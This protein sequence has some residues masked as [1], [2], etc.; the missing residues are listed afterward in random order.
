MNHYYNKKYHP[1]LMQSSLKQSGTKTVNKKN[2]LRILKLVAFTFKDQSF[3]FFIQ[4]SHMPVQGYM[5]QDHLNSQWNNLQPK[6]NFSNSTCKIF[7]F[8]CMCELCAPRAQW[9]G[10]S[11]CS[12]LLLIKWHRCKRFIGFRG[13]LQG[14][15]FAGCVFMSFWNEYSL[16][17]WTRKA[18]WRDHCNVNT[19]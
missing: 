10:N 1:L 6:P 19:K 3:S 16:Q 17:Y 15:T 4:P 5:F 12:V 7:S 14:H 8:A 13:E 18:E 11:V 9:N 2:L